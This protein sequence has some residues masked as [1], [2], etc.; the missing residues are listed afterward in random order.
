[1]GLFVGKSILRISTILIATCGLLFLGLLA[2][3][4][5]SIPIE[6]R[7]HAAAV[8]FIS[9]AFLPAA[10]GLAI[11]NHRLALSVFLAGA[12]IAVDLL[13]YMK[14]VRGVFSAMPVDCPLGLC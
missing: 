4:V 3:F 13:F 11:S 6:H 12:V 7:A 8:F 14:V 9:F 1:M 2:F 5:D 10:V